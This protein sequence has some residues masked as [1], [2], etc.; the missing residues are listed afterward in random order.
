MSIRVSM[1]QCRRMTDA[2]LHFQA[3][4][5][6]REQAASRTMSETVKDIL[7]QASYHQTVAASLMNFAVEADKSLVSPITPT[8]DIDIIAPAP[9][10]N[11]NGK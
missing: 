7:D 4:I 8:K 3:A 6:L 10:T 5:S 11:G 1:D 2:A 9:E